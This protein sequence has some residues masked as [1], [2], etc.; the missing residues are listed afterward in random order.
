M[1]KDDQILIV[2]HSC[3]CLIYQLQMSFLLFKTV[4]KPVY[5]I[6]CYIHGIIE[7][8]VHLYALPYSLVIN[9]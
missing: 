2:V 3:M 5:F 1:S 8:S 7:A 4:N 9:Q 6:F